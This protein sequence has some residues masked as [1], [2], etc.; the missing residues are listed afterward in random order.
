MDNEKQ[1]GR[2]VRGSNHFSFRIKGI[3]GERANE[4]IKRIEASPL[5]ELIQKYL[6]AV[7]EV[8]KNKE[9]SPEA[10][11]GKLLP[12]L[13]EIQQI[14]FPN[15]PKYYEWNQEE[16]KAVLADIIP[17]CDDG[18]ID[19]KKELNLKILRPNPE[20]YFILRD[21]ELKKLGRLYV[22]NRNIRLSEEYEWYLTYCRDI[23]PISE[24][25]FKRM[26]ETKEID[27]T[28]PEIIHIP[29]EWDSIPKE[30]ITPTQTH[31]SISEIWPNWLLTLSQET[32]KSKD[33]LTQILVCYTIKRALNGDE[34]AIQKLY[35]LY[36]EAAVG[37]AVNVAKK[38]RSLQS[39][40]EM[41]QDA[42]ILLRLLIGGFKPEYIFSE[43]LRGNGFRTIDAIPKRTKMFYL[44]YLSKWIP[45]K[46]TEIQKKA[47]QIRV[48]EAMG[49][50]KDRWKVDLDLGLEIGVLL[51]PYTPIHEGTRRGIKYIFNTYSYQPS[52]KSPRGHLTIWLFGTSEKDP[53]SILYGLLRDNYRS[54]IRK[55]QKEKNFDFVDDFDEYHEESLSFKGRATALKAKDVPLDKSPEEIIEELMKQEFSK[56]DA[57]IFV[58]HKFLGTPQRE[59]KTEYG[60]SER[61]IREICK[62][63][64]RKISSQ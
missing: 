13:H 61:W 9:L 62:R 55:L 18:Y 1:I 36:E 14:F 51:N 56:R 25:E 54:K 7:D 33:L 10:K 29:S 34:K 8:K 46:L 22:R 40:N 39:I 2:E 23:K 6:D 4:L 52:K 3:L 58:K 17:F 32:I 26:L 60:L 42:K 53:K 48:R 16:K 49:L 31:K 37:L 28:E 44:Y 19:L 59:L 12:P 15:Y 57:E 50:T 20:K 47:G 35:D 5:A 64:E 24:A 43:L 38:L 11:L 45:Q 21:T 27:L 63:I 30:R 41:K